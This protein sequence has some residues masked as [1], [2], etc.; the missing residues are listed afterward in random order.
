LTTFTSWMALQSSQSSFGIMAGSQR[1]KIQRKHALRHRYAF[2]CMCFLAISVHPFEHTVIVTYKMRHKSAAQVNSCWLFITPRPDCV[3]LGT[4]QQQAAS[5]CV[6]LVF[7]LLIYLCRAAQDWTICCTAQMQ[8]SAAL[9]T[10]QSRL[11]LTTTWKGKGP[12]CS[13]C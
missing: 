3:A 5:A 10:W 12:S 1:C 9:L 6:G 7:N 4:C 2:C 8:T 11:Q 13:V